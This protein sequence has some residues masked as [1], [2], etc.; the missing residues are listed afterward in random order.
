MDVLQPKMVCFISMFHTLQKSKKS[1]PI[2]HAIMNAMD[3]MSKSLMISSVVLHLYLSSAELPD[4][5]F[6]VVDNAC[7][8]SVLDK[9]DSSKDEFNFLSQ[10]HIC[11][12]QAFGLLV[13]KWCIFKKPL[14]VKLWCTTLIIEA[15]FHLHNFSINMHDSSIVGTGN[16]DPD[17]FCLS[18]MEY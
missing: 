15:T 11:I 16:C 12:E 6:V 7:T 9:Q 4:G 17:T 13:S 18:Y 1:N 10:P 5:Y 3:L 8:S 14:E 2:F